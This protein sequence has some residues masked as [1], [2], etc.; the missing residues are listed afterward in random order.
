M[1]PFQHEGRLVRLSPAMTAMAT[2]VLLAGLSLT[3]LA[4]PGTTMTATATPTV[5]ERFVAAVNRGDTRSFLALFPKDGIVNDWGRTFVGHD[6]IRAWSDKEF[7]GAKGHLTVKNVQTTGK[8]V[9]V[10][11]G[12]KSN[13]YSGDSRF[14]FELDGEQIREMRITSDK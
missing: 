8:D 5:I 11:A 1:L 3:V 7:I 4:Q 10:R 12:W 9:S 13:F 6:A 14:V 2:L